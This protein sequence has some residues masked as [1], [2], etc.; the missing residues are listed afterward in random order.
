M[1]S[2]PQLQM[3]ANVEVQLKEERRK[4][5]EREKHDCA[6]KKD[7]AT[8]QAEAEEI[9]IPEWLEKYITYKFSLYDRAGINFARSVPTSK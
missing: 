7:D 1:L 3:W 8:S 5:L 2:L 6:E 4:K 9:V